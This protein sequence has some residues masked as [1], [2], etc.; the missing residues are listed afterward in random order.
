MDFAKKLAEFGVEIISTGGT[1]K[2]LKENGLEVREISEVTGFPEMLDGRVKTLHP[3]IHAGLLARRD[4]PDHMKAIGDMGIK[5]LIVEGGG[6]TIAS[7]FRDGLVD[8]FTVFV[9]SQII[10]GRTSPTPADGDGRVVPEGL[11]LSL[12]DAEILG[13]GVLLTYI[14]PP[15]GAVQ[16]DLQ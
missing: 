14:V 6:E 7:F 16:E 1:Y 9:G 10:G 3:K 8:K 5:S 11:R 15:E 4:I 2:L 12:E 13:D